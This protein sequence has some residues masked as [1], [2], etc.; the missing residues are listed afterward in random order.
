MIDAVRYVVTFL[1]AV[2]VF[3]LGM[4]CERQRS[5]QVLITAS[6]RR[7]LS[8]PEALEI[9]QHILKTQ[10]P[11]RSLGIRVHAY[12][13][14]YLALSAP[15]SLNTN[16]HGTA[17]A[18][19]LYSL[20]VLTCYY[21]ARSW[22]TSQPDL[23]DYILVAKSAKIQYKRPVTACDTIVASCVL[24]DPDVLEKFRE[25]LV[26]AAKKGYLEV[27]GRVNSDDGNAACECI[28]ELCAYKLEEE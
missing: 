2:G 14:T 7:F 15:L 1:V 20:I 24:P 21:A 28:V 26:S 8:N 12:S 13:G 25:Q 10:K 22:I 9:E 11:A 4:W 23:Q 27:E 16:V 18:G 6:R 19:S 17:F 5:K 3:L